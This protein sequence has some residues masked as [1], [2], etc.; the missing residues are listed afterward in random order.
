MIDLALKYYAMRRL[1]FTAGRAGCA[2][3]GFFAFVSSLLVPF[4]HVDPRV[5]TLHELH[6]GWTDKRF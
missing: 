3:Q 4:T 6:N 2:P 5:S 1:R